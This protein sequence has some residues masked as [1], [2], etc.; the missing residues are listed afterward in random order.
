[1]TP[2]RPGL[3]LCMI[4][5]DEAEMLPG[6]LQSVSGLADE[7]I[8]VDTGSADETRRIAADFGA[9]VVDFQWGDDFSAARNVSLGAATGRWI[10]WLDA[11]ERLRPDEHDRVRALIGRGAHEAYLVPILSPRPSGPQ[12]SRGH[13]LFRRGGGIRFTGRVHEQVGPALTRAG[14][15]VGLA[16]FTIDHLGYNLDAMAQRAKDERNARLLKMARKDRPHDAY[17]RFTLA[18]H[19]MGTGDH[20]SARQ[21]LEAALGERADLRMN[22]PLPRDILASAYSNLAS[23]AI[24]RGSLREAL[25]R[26]DESLQA[27][28]EQVMAHLLAYRAHRAMDRHDAALI[29]LK[30]AKA[31]LDHPPAHGGA[32]IEPTVDPSEIERGMGECCLRLERT[33]EAREHLE[34]AKLAAPDRPAVLSSLARCALAEGRG[35]VALEF[36]EKALGLAPHDDSLLDLLGFILLKLG[37]FVEAAERLGELCLRRPADPDL[38]RR[39]A[40]VLVKAGRTKEAADLISAMSD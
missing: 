27:V 16:D 32:A 25:A 14:Y 1:M 10:L 5:K 36:A 23:I 7:I 24:E 17:V 37:R 15:H 13:R 33:A 38:K 20:V 40:G 12:L 39:L 22:D 8:I 28:P 34:T 21:E 31:F 19:Y 9:T 26:V 2:D 11:D 4:V 3:S 18:Q 29:D 30:A 6:C 35:D